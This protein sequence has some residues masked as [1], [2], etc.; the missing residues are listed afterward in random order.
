MENLETI[1]DLPDAI[2]TAED[3]VDPAEAPSLAPVAGDSPEMTPD[4]QTLISEAEQ[5][6]Y[7][8]GRNE[9]IEAE[10][11]S[12]SD[13]YFGLPA[14]ASSSGSADPDDGDDDDSCPGF[15]AH[16]RPGFWD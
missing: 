4:L 16:L 10:I 1:P 2:V 11:M 12:P 8:R 15:L 7:L 13:P 6:G 9:R 14:R 3:N 5:R